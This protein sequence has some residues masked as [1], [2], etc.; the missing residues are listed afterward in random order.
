MF[1]QKFIEKQA[2]AVYPTVRGGVVLSMFQQK[3]TEKQA[4]AV[5]P[6]V[7][8]GVVLSMFQQK[9][10]GKQANAVYPTVRGGVV[11]TGLTNAHRNVE[12]LFYLSYSRL[13]EL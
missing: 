3:F 12:R 4:N 6:P 9:F 11:S 1:Q 13:S 5:Y 2:N 8:G 10:T 7:R